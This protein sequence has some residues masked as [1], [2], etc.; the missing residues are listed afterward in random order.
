[1]R[2]LVFLVTLT[3]VSVCEPDAST[4]LVQTTPE[5]LRLDA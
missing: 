1:M 5:A 2:S 4:G 3:I